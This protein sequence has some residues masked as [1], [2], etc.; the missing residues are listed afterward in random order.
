MYAIKYYT[1]EE[2]WS[3]ENFYNQDDI[4]TWMIDIETLK[5]A[6][7]FAKEL[8]EIY[9]FGEKGYKKF[10]NGKEFGTYKEDRISGIADGIRVW[11]E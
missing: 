8:V 7:E 11:I 3:K 5:K 2:D 6:I 9:M 4:Q 10:D 1:W